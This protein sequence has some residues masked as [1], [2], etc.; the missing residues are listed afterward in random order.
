[1]LPSTTT[2]TQPALFEDHAIRRE[3]HEGVWHWAA[4]SRSS[5]LIRSA[6]MLRN[7]QM[8]A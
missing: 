6:A 8:F 7:S 5:V 1:M 4:M 2:A 3:M